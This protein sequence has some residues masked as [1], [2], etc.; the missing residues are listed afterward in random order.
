MI[1]VSEHDTNND[2]EKHDLFRSERKVTVTRRE[3]DARIDFNDIVDHCIESAPSNQSPVEMLMDDDYYYHILTPVDANCCEEKANN[4]ITHAQVPRHVAAPCTTH[5]H[6][7]LTDHSFGGYSHEKRFNYFR[8]R[9][10]SKQVA[11][12]MV[13]QQDAKLIEEII[14]VYDG[15]HIYYDVSGRILFPG[16]ADEYAADEF[17][18][19][20]GELDEVA[21]E[22][23]IDLANQLLENGWIVQNIPSKKEKFRSWRKQAAA[24]KLNLFNWE[25]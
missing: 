21:Q 14:A 17:D 15:E 24:I 12:E 25:K 7:E 16:Y 1:I 3:I 4:V 23:A 18:V 6:V 8:K 19:P 20:T 13:A 5:C 2:V 10:A 22:I 11:A 9:G